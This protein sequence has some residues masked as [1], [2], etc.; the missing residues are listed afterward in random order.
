[1]FI[2]FVNFVQSAAVT[3]ALRCS[4]YVFVSSA[5]ADS[6]KMYFL[7]IVIICNHICFIMLGSLIMDHT[8]LTV[9]DPYLTST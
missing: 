8:A 5:F 4:Q 3:H 9:I 6:V 7:I 2:D 1:L